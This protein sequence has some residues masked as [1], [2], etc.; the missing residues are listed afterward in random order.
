MIGN[1]GID[2]IETQEVVETLGDVPPALLDE[3]PP[4][5]S[6]GLEPQGRRTRAARRTRRNGNDRTN[7]QE[8]RR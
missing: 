7:R 4:E 2:A 6:P 1:G 8:T 3:L 5:L